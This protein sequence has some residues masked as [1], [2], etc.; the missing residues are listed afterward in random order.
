MRTYTQLTQVQR[1][2]V[3]ALMKAGHNQSEIAQLVDVHKSTISPRTAPQPK[4]ALARQE[5]PPS[6]FQGQL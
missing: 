1:Y 2:Q 3:Y 4:L 6:F 5:K